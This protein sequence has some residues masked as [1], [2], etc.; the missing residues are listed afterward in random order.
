V[1]APSR[2][3]VCARVLLASAW[4]LS[5]SKLPAQ[6]TDSPNEGRTFADSVQAAVLLLPKPEGCVA[7]LPLASMHR[8]RVLLDATLPTYSE[9]D[10]RLQADL[11]AQDIAAELRKLL[12]ASGDTIPTADTTFVWYSVPTALTV[13][14][15]SNGEMSARP[16]GAIGDSAATLLLLRAYNVARAQSEAFIAWPDGHVGDSLV[17][18]L[19]LRPEYVGDKPRLME[20]GKV[21]RKFVAFYLTEPERVSAFQLLGQGIPVYPA[22]EE[23]NR[24]EGEVLLQFII[25]STGRVER[26]SI[27]DPWPVDKPYPRGYS[28]TIYEDFARSAK[29]WIRD[30]RFSPAR[31]G[32]CLVS[33]AALLPLRFKAP[34]RR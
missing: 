18:H 23:M 5:A 8:V 29:S 21:I 2:C 10:F 20:P 11:M 13:V 14:A 24:L 31:I 6:R 32:T 22:R 19:E 30:L 27:H 28:A 26:E 3:R 15:H 12:G 25:D 1:D 33:Q 4:A 7:A 17:L 34:G 16:L 9:G